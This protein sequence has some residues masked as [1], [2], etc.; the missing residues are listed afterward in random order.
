MTFNF[1][2]DRDDALGAEG[3]VPLNLD[4]NA[5]DADTIPPGIKALGSMKNAIVGAFKQGSV[6][7]KQQAPTHLAP[8]VYYTLEE[9]GDP[10]FHLP[11][12]FVPKTVR[13]RVD[14]TLPLDFN[15]YTVFKGFE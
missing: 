4:G 3:F 1:G 5:G 7:H 11:D 14:E 8:P 9:L 6:H 2:S 10:H 15:P 13:A 12:D